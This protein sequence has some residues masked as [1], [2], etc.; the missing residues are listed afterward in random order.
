MPEK[1]FMIGEKK[2]KRKK[3]GKG[4]LRGSFSKRKT[5]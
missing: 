5:L 2:K 1:A 4:R 3:E